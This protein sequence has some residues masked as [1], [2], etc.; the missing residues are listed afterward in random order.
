ML[1][2][3]VSPARTDGR[4][5]LLH[6]PQLFREGRFRPSGRPEHR[7]PGRGCLQ[8]LGGKGFFDSPGSARPGPSVQPDLRAIG[9]ALLAKE[10]SRNA[11]SFSNHREFKERIRQEY[12]VS[13]FECRRCSNRCQ[14]NK[15]G[16][17]RETLFFGDTCERYTSQ[18]TISPRLRKR[19]SPTSSGSGRT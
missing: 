5:R 8:C 15:I 18:Q 19:R 1:R 10:K 11:A 12:S 4:P 17:G 3:G 6:C 16:I 9:A 13:S 2:A 14:V 7:L